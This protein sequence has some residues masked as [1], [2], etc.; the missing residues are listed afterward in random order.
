MSQATTT[1]IT[2]KDE[3]KNSVEAL[4]ESLNAT[5]MD[6]EVKQQLNHALEKMRADGYSEQSV[7]ESIQLLNQLMPPLE[8]NI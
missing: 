1:S 8:T 3:D 6:D 7:A 2:T 5:D 4:L